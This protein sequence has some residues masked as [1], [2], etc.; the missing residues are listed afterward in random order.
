MLKSKKEDIP[1]RHEWSGNLESEDSTSC[2]SSFPDR[3]QKAISVALLELSNDEWWGAS[4]LC[5]PGRRNLGGSAP[6]LLWHPGQV[7]F[8]EPS[9]FQD[10]HKHF[11]AS[12][13]RSLESHATVRGDHETLRN[14][15][16]L[17]RQQA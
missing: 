1:E 2:I 13:C 16:P 15:S 14:A 7:L 9:I 11:Q 6:S 5:W 12:L 17:R 8:Q 10:I 4:G 3:I